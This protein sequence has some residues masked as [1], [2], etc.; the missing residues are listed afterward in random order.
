L[1]WSE[2]GGF[3]TPHSHLNPNF[4]IFSAGEGFNGAAE[5][6][7]HALEAVTDAEE[8]QAAG[9]HGFIGGGSLVVY[10]FWRTGQDYALYRRTGDLGGKSGISGDN[11]GI[12]SH[13]SY[14]PTNELGCLASKVKD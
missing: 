3:P 4:P 5:V 6:K 2:G 1:G 8:G 10:G 12:Y 14:A 7:G 13:I 9:I 11:F